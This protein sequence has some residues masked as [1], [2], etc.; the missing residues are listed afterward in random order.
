MQTHGT[1]SLSRGVITR[2]SLF[3][4]IHKG[5]FHVLNFHAGNNPGAGGDWYCDANLGNNIW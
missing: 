4:E 1:N 3:K 5:D 2:I